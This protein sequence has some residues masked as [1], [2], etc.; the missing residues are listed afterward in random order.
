[1]KEREEV[2]RA[3]DCHEEMEWGSDECDEEKISSA[4]GGLE[5]VKAEELG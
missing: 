4:E 2:P 1:M 3:S 5:F